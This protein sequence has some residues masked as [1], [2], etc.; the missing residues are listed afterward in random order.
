MAVGFLVTVSTNQRSHNNFNLYYDWDGDG[1]PEATT[2]IENH[3]TI[4]NRD[5]ILFRSENSWHVK[6][7][8]IGDFNNDEVDELGIGFFRKGDYGA[9]LKYLKSRRDPNDSFHLFLYQYDNSSKQFKLIWGSST[10]P[11]P[12]AKMVIADMDG[13]NVLKVTEASYQ[14]WDESR[15][16]KPIKDSFWIWNEWWFEEYQ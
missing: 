9:E 7:F 5:D 13:K 16:L 2:L 3:L 11:H 10:L 12:I 14:D 1:S 8:L 15:T 6:N 4:R